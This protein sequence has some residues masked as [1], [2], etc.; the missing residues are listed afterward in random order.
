MAATCDVIYVAVFA[1]ETNKT[2]RGFDYLKVQRKFIICAK[3]QVNK[4][5]R[6]GKTLYL[7]RVVHIYIPRTYSPMWP[8]SL[9]TT[10][11]LAY[12]YRQVCGFF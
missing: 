2:P 10:P 8:S 7:L 3:C 5:E 12:S 9:T 6:K 1:M 4:K 11:A